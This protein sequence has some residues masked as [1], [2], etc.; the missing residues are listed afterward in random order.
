LLGFIQPQ[1]EETIHP[2][3]AMLVDPGALGGPVD[4]VAVAADAKGPLEAVSL[5]LDGRPVPLER[6]GDYFVHAR[7]D[8][9]SLQGKPATL[10]LS[11]RR[12][13]GEILRSRLEIRARD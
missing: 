8:P 1:G 13:S 9:A 3:S 10:T 6:W 5:E 7:I 12:E 4:L 11:G 2:A